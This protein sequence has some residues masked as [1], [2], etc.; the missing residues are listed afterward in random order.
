MNRLFY[1]AL[2]AF[3]AATAAYAA[4][5]PAAPVVVNQFVVTDGYYPDKVPP[6]GQFGYSDTTNKTPAT[7]NYTFNGQR[8]GVGLIFGQSHSM[9]ACSGCSPHNPTNASSCYNLNIYDG[10]Q[11]LL[12]DPPLGAA[13]DGGSFLTWATLP[14]VAGTWGSW[15][16]YLC[17]TVINAGRFTELSLITPS[18]GGS[19]ITDWSRGVYWQRARVGLMWARA[20]NL[21][22]S[23]VMWIQGQANSS[24]NDPF[25]GSLITTAQYM[26][27]LHLLQQNVAALAPNDPPWI[28][29]RDT[30]PFLVGFACT[31]T[32]TTWPNAVNVD[33]AQTGIIDNKK[34]FQPTGASLL[35]F[36]F[37][38]TIGVDGL[39]YT[40]LGQQL[41]GNSLGQ[42][43]I[44]CNCGI[45]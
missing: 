21:P 36:P 35:N 44:N 6:N 13:A 28:V 17:D 16:G 41:V 34:F 12:T 19:F 42:A 33:A 8:P 18:Q 43:L 3:I 7:F 40:D 29:V 22:I 30:C 25:Y 20:N 45:P 11:Y 2:A 15:F 31:S 10:H 26:T 37:A 39:H 5:F 4:M 38:T 24:A 27:E 32:V 9:G 1:A 23:F 14:T